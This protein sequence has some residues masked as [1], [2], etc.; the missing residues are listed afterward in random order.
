MERYHPLKDLAPR[1]IVARAIDAELKRTG[2]D[3]VYLDMTHLPK[4]FLLEHFP[5]IDAQCRGFGI[6]MAVQPIPVVPAAHYTCGGVVTNVDGETT[7]PGLLAAGEVACTG[8]HGANR[9]ASNSILEGLVFGNRA[10][11]KARDL[12][13]HL[14]PPPNA[15]E[16]DPGTA[17]PPEEG[18]VVS[19]NWDEIRRFMWNYVGIVRTSKRL[20]RAGRR[21]ELLLEEIHEYY[22]HTLVTSDLLELRNLA[23]VARLIINSA[24]MRHESRGLHYTLDY[25]GMAPEAQDTVIVRGKPAP[26]AWPR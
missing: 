4:A 19:Q 1:D 9:L 15:P 16:W 8:L 24:R 17:V 20:D 14:P 12:L 23:E 3:C 11:E 10:A 18:V 21:I 26:E 6:D 25:P 2:N 13:Q 7:L 5:N 22:W